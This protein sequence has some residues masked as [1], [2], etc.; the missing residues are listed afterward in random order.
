LGGDLI[1]IAEFRKLV[2]QGQRL[3]RYKDRYVS[4]NS[5][6]VKKILDASSK[7]PPSKMSP[8]QILK[9]VGVTNASIIY[10]QFVA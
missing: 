9:E 2:A 3:I 8:Y 5:G 1:S 4:L 6:D 7:Q 10:E